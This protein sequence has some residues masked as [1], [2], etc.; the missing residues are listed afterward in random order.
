[1]DRD[2]LLRFIPGV[3]ETK[4]TLPL[5]AAL[6]RLLVWCILLGSPVGEEVFKIQ[7]KSYDISFCPIHC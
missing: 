5:D 2:F 1:L 6:G 7:D 4:I 3:R